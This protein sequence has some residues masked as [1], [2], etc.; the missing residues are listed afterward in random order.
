[1]ET[2]EVE[3]RIRER[4]AQQLGQAILNNIEAGETIRDLALQ[5]SKLEAELK[6]LKTEE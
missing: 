2:Q 6:E 4:I 5:N 1:M 3:T